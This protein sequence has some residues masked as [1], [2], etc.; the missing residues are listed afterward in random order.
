MRFDPCHRPL[1][2]EFALTFNNAAASWAEFH[3]ASVDDSD[4][5]LN[6]QP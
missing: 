2:A 4:T 1:T 3:R 5:V 6:P